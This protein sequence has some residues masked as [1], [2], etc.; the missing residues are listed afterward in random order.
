MRRCS[1]GCSLPKIANRLIAG[2][3]GRYGSHDTAF[4]PKA[5]AREVVADL[6]PLWANLPTLSCRPWP[7]SR[8]LDQRRVK[9][10]HHA[11]RSQQQVRSIAPPVLI[12]PADGSGHDGFLNP[13]HACLG[14]GGLASPGCL[15]LVISLVFIG[16]KLISMPDIGKPAVAC[17]WPFF[18]SAGV[19]LFCSGLLAETADCATFI[20]KSQGRPIYRVAG[21]PWPAGGPSQCSAAVSRRLPR[22]RTSPSAARAATRGS[23]S[24]APPQ[25]GA[26]RAIPRSQGPG[27][28]AS[29]SSPLPR[30]GD[31]EFAQEPLLLP[32]T[33][34]E[35]PKLQISDP[36]PSQGCA[37]IWSWS[38]VCGLCDQTGRGQSTPWAESLPGPEARWPRPG[39][40]A[41][42]TK[43]NAGDQRAHL[44]NA[45]S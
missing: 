9:V 16:E 3:H 28:A 23:E 41:Q 35:R 37:W 30:K 31:S 8:E 29:R 2:F 24:E 45:I 5:T 43:K 36:L 6:K 42:A 19:Q 25:K 4:A 21:T 13:T 18:A 1:G 15:G 27:M 22:N 7:S 39:H 38:L 33:S 17:R 26:A 32:L 12:G 10:N 44:K 34:A 11:R 40:R 14:F 20:T